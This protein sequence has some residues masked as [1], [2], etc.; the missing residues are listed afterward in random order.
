M[1][2]VR[3]QPMSRSFSDLGLQGDAAPLDYTQAAMLLTCVLSEYAGV[4]TYEKFRAWVER[5]PSYYRRVPNAKIPHRKKMIKDSHALFAKMIAKRMNNEALDDLGVIKERD[6]WVGLTDKLPLPDDLVRHAKILG[7]LAHLYGQ[8]DFAR[9]NFA[10]LYQ[11]TALMPLKARMERL[12]KT[13][14][15]LQKI[16]EK[17][18]DIDPVLLLW[19]LGGAIPP[20]VPMS[21]GVFSVAPEN[22]YMA[23]ALEVIHM[24]YAIENPDA[25][26]LTKTHSFTRDELRPTR[27][28]F[29]IGEA[30]HGLLGCWKAPREGEVLLPFIV[31]HAFPPSMNPLLDVAVRKILS[32]FQAEVTRIL[33]E[34]EALKQTTTHQP[35]VAQVTPSPAAFSQPSTKEV[36]VR[37]P[38]TTE[39]HA[40][41]A[42]YLK[43]RRIT[44]DTFI[45]DVAEEIMHDLELQK[46]SHAELDRQIKVAL[47]HPSFDAAGRPATPI[48]AHIARALDLTPSEART[49]FYVKMSDL[50]NAAKFKLK[51]QANLVRIMRLDA[52]LRGIT[53]FNELDNSAVTLTNVPKCAYNSGRPGIP[54][55]RVANTLSARGEKTYSTEDIVPYS[56]WSEIY[57]HR[58][59]AP[60]PHGQGSHLAVVRIR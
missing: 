5:I 59:N 27:R 55:I 1:E 38:R 20:I 60:K 44:V 14:E 31:S 47:K 25:P 29:G 3:A 28:I 33:E 19:L 50:D 36:V 16:V 24:A 54:L 9:N 13:P 15:D 6:I 57:D 52:Q 58:P 21:K 23:I 34:E 2:P 40:T 49:S 35:A 45:K 22:T 51:I 39:V 43:T 10:S 46:P 41:V 53:S 56:E 11:R 18:P 4:D 42:A 48:W 7:D 12:G 17:R 26:P 8:P 30:P 37:Q 32:Q